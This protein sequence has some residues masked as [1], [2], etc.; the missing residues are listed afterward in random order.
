MRK[1]LQCNNLLPYDAPDC[2]H[3]R[4][5]ILP[6][7]STYVGPGL[8]MVLS[9]LAGLLFLPPHRG[10]PWT[11]FI[12]CM[13]IAFLF[14]IAFITGMIPVMRLIPDIR[15]M[16]RYRRHKKHDS[17]GSCYCNYC[18]KFTG[19]TW[20][21]CI[22]TV[23]G[24]HRSVYEEGHDWDR[25]ICKVCGEHKTDSQTG[26]DWDGCTCTICGMHRDM[27]HEW[28]GCKCKRCGWSRDRDH[29]LDGCR[30]TR[31]GAMSHDWQE[32]GRVLQR[33]PE[34]DKFFNEHP[35]AGWYDPDKASWYDVTYTCSRCGEERDEKEYLY[36]Q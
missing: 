4:K 32:S 27:W 5:V 26:H 22:C 25:C 31:C 10:V 34:Y 33:D 23:C 13:S 17:T 1:C 35:N 9:A 20:A 24:A 36:T 12:I 7:M 14:L 3:C 30:C 16:R 15:T 29:E 8:G 11:G 21:G 28:E 2:P 6:Q 19:H 18:G